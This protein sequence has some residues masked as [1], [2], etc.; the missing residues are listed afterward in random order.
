MIDTH[1]HIYGPEFDSD[2]Q[3]AVIERA[4]K[5]GVGMMLMPNVDLESIEPMRRLNSLMPQNT[6]MAMG[7]H[8]TELGDDAKTT[9]KIVLDELARNRNDYVAIGEIGID[10][11]WDKSREKEQM[12]I[13]DIQLSEAEKYGLNVLI[14]CREAL[15]QTL[16]VLQ[17]HPAV[18]AVFH[19]FGGSRDD[20]DAIRRLGDYYF[21]I[22][23]VVTFKNSG[24]REVL[25]HIGLDR[26]LTETD[27]PYLSPVPHRGKR[28]ESSYIPL[29]VNTIATSLGISNEEVDEKTTA[30]AIDFIPQLSLVGMQ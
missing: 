26:I 18:G 19:S 21:G 29:I 8:P 5:V 25:P 1:T 4:I 24:L 2:P 15:S 10:L 14:H 20:V 12:E 17:G 11:Y 22:N 13:F 27:S 16:E 28:N 23:G 7:L 3:T 30:N 9:L 6:R